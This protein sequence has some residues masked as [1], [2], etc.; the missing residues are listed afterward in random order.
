MTLAELRA[1]LA[2]LDHLPDDTIVILAKD[3]E[4][5]GFSPLV[6]ADH[7]MYLADTTW[8]GERYL[9][10]EQRLAETNPDD[11]SE[12]PDDAVPAVFLWPTN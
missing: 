5:N 7:G 11:Y 10:D 4:G 9:T 12:A 6:E 1:A 8:S 3:A 2:K